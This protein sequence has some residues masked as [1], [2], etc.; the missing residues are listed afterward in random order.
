MQRVE[1]ISVTVRSVFSACR[2][3][4]ARTRCLGAGSYR[5]VQRII[6]DRYSSVDAAPVEQ[7]QARVACMLAARAL[8]ESGEPPAT[9]RAQIEAITTAQQQA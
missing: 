9:S 5:W 1:G 2:Y 6:A 7:D 4:R 3:Q 8:F